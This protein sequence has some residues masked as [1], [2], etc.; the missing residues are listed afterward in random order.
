MG[1][2]YVKSRHGVEIPKRTE[3]LK[4]VARKDVIANSL[5]LKYQSKVD[6]QVI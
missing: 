3:R 2:E 5:S 4:V 1:T 6:G